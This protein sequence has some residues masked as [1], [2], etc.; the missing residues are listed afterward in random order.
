[1]VTKRYASTVIDR[2]TWLYLHSG[3][4]GPTATRHVLTGQIPPPPRNNNLW[5][6]DNKCV[7]YHP[8]LRDP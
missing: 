8:H 5:V 7:K 4:Y 1:M 6:M 3:T 2:R